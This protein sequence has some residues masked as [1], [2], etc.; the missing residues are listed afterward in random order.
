M[1][2]QTI[3][4]FSNTVDPS[5]SV[6]KPEK[7]EDKVIVYSTN[8]RVSCDSKQGLNFPETLEPEKL[9]D[10]MKI[11]KDEHKADKDSECVKFQLEYDD[12]KM[13]VRLYK[14][15]VKLD[16]PNST[17]K[18]LYDECIYKPKSTSNQSGIAL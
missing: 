13:P 8:V 10:M 5:K 18:E 14:R 4:R 2:T 7:G 17:T 16:Q 3:V 1:E 6:L 15:N 11:R 9:A 12:N